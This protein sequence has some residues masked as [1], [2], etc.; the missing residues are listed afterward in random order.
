MAPVVIETPA[1]EDALCVIVNVCPAIISLPVLE[2]PV[3]LACTANPT[4][5]LPVP[6]APEET[7]IQDALLLAVQEHPAVVK[8][9]TDP[10][11]APDAIACDEADRLYVQLDPWVTI[12]VNTR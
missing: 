1:V 6:G 10:L 9:F 3:V 8:T 4:G 5:P 12:S 2:A 7:L 11:A